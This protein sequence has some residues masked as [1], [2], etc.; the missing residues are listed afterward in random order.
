MRIVHYYSHLNGLEHILVHKPELWR[1]INEV[2]EVVDANQHKTKVSEEKSMVGR[3]LY[4]PTSLN[5]ALKTEL[6]TR[7]WHQSRTSYYVTHDHR[8]IRKTMNLPRDEQKQAILDAGLKPL[9][10]YNQTDFVKDRVEIE[11]Q[12]GKY[13]FVAFD[14]FVKHMAFFVGDVIDVGVEIVPMKE[15]QA[16]MS[17]GPPHYEGCLYDLLRQGRSTPAVPL[18]LVGVAP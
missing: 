16:H 14:L 13:S 8:L 4:A 17:S 1:E 5:I 2:I 18:V 9:L 10:S 11:V 7:G 6:T 12:F 3:M 15:M